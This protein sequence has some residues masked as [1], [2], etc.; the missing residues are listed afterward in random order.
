MRALHIEHLRDRPTPHLSGGE[1]RLVSLAG[2]L[3]MQPQALLLDEP[4]CG[5]DED[6]EEVVL[7]ALEAVDCA[8]LIVSHEP[9]VAEHLHARAFRLADGIVIE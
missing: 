2:V 4:T 7:A 9:R 1:C 6:A 5:L 3:I 8:M